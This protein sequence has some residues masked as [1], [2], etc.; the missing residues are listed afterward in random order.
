MTRGTTVIE[1]NDVP[2]HQGADYPSPYDGQCDVRRKVR[3]GDAGGLTQYGVNLVTLPPGSW[4][5]QRHWHSHEDEFVWIVS[6]DAT[7]VTEDGETP[8]KA[9]MVATFPAGA[10]DGHHLVNNSAG[11]VVYLE[12]GSRSSDDVCYYPDIDLHLQPDGKGGHH[13]VHKDGTAYRRAKRK[14]RRLHDAP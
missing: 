12:V 8:L 13:F 14:G 7:L 2:H 5:T 10:A 3:L 11:D 9:S 1:P 4:S 6:G